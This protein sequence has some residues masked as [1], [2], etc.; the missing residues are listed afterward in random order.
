VNAAIARY[1]SAIPRSAIILP[2]GTGSHAQDM[3]IV[4]PRPDHTT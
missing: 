4:A 2:Y 3:A 1:L